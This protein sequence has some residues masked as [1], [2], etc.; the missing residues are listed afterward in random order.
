[1]E[2]NSTLVQTFNTFEGKTSAQT[3]PCTGQCIPAKICY[4]RSGS[5]AIAFQNCIPGF[6][7]VQ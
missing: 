4:M 2:I 1:M 6:G 3:S 7:S 5:A